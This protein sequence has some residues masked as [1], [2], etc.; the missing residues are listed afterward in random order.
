VTFEFFQFE[1]K[2]KDGHSQDA[3]AVAALTSRCHVCSHL[4]PAWAPRAR[5]DGPDHWASG[6]VATRL[7]SRA[8]LLLAS[9]CFH[10]IL[11]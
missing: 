4:V 8:E 1:W 5:G 11:T 10:S 2:G 9:S 7:R 6:Q 3:K